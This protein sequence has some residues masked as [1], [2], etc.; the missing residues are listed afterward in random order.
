VVAVLQKLAAA[1]GTDEA[2][3]TTVDDGRVFV[4]FVSGASG[5][6]NGLFATLTC[7]ADG[8]Y[9]AVDLYAWP[10]PARIP[11]REDIDPALP[12]ALTGPTQ[13]LHAEGSVLAGRPVDV[14]A[15]SLVFGGRGPVVK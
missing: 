15:Y 6:E 2:D 3:C 9:S 12:D 13:S 5:Q 11:A 4:T 8:R 10:C 7:A 1:F 14:A